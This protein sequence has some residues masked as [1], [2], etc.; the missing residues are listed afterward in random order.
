MGTKT[1]T[2]ENDETLLV[3]YSV[4]HLPRRVALQDICRK[5]IRQLVCSENQINSLPL[6]IKVK[7]YLNYKYSSR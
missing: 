4:M 7:N 1:A 2:N 6:P 5:K 3:E